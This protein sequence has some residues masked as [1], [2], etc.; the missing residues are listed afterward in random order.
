MEKN[1]IN[2]KGKD[3]VSFIFDEKQKRIMEK[4]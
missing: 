4:E 3:K 2:K 1:K